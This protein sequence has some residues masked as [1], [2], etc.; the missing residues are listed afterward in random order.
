MQSIKIIL[1]C[2]G[3]A[4]LYGIVHD[5]V[6]ARICV[7]YFSVFHPPIFP[8]QSPTL[9]ALG[10]GVLATWWVGAFLGVLLALA[11]RAG[12]R[13]KIASKELVLPIVKLLATMGVSAAVAGILGFVLSS[14]GAIAPPQWIASVLPRARH[15]R[16][17]ADWWAHSAS[18][19]VGFFGGIALCI[20][21]FRSRRLKVATW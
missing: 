16:F 21:T 10:W 1:T 8:T 6:T 14:R 2:V 15:A 19:F 5:Q 9:L 13:P 7:E 20:V 11:A 18:Y 3:A 4:A 17:M 12:S